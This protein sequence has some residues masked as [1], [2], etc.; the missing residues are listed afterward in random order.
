MIAQGRKLLFFPSPQ[1]II[2]VP[3]PLP[4]PRQADI[5]EL[6]QEG[7]DGGLAWPREG[8]WDKSDDLWKGKKRQF[9]ILSDH[10]GCCWRKN[11]DPNWTLESFENSLFPFPRTG[12]EGW[13]DGWM[14]GWMEGW[15]EGWMEGWIEG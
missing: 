1:I 12:M 7:A 6:R 8:M 9:R 10:L 4:R 2:L 5:G 3:H 15:L 11:L 13:M 14:D